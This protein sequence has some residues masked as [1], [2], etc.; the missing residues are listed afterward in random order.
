MIIY[1]PLSSNLSSSQNLHPGT[2][3]TSPEPAIIP[4]KI[5]QLNCHNSF[6]VTSNAL[7][8]DSQFAILVLQEPMEIA[9]FQLSI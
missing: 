1:D 3:S 6:D 9:S 7:N 8:S 5:L 4:F 2:S